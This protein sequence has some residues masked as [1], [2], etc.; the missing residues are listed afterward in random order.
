MVV[1]VKLAAVAQLVANVVV[2]VLG[3]TMRKKTRAET[4]AYD[5]DAAVDV[6]NVVATAADVDAA[7]VKVIELVK[8]S[9]PC[10]IRSLA[11]AEKV[12]ALRALEV[13]RKNFGGAG[14]R[15]AVCAAVRAILLLPT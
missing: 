7:L 12:A 6:P 9:D 8:A 1:M 10:G 13:Q 3:K 11:K 15:D 4:D 2:A 14:K 5:E